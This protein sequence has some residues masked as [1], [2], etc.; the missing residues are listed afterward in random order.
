MTA[1]VPPPAI[2]RL[3]APFT[4]DY[5]SAPDVVFTAPDGYFDLP[6]PMF[7]EC[8]ELT[9]LTSPVFTTVWVH[10]AKPGETAY[11]SIDGDVVSEVTVANNR[12][13][14]TQVASGILTKGTHY[15][16]CT[17]DGV[18]V[19]RAMV[20]Q[21]APAPEFEPVAAD[22]PPEIVSEAAQ[23]NGNYRWVLQDLAQGGIG[24]WVMPINPSSMAPLPRQKEV[25]ASVTTSVGSSTTHLAESHP[26]PQ[27]WSFQGFCPDFEFYNRISQYKE[28]NR[29]F[30]LI[31][32]RNRAW[33]V[34]FNSLEM[35]PRKRLHG[36]DG[37]YND[38][39]H[40]Y[41]VKATV[42]E[43]QPKTPE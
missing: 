25:N 36:D 18:T 10:N 13:A 43:Q 30:Y 20:V 16:E 41:T 19:R 27:D 6:T 21:K 12:S 15:I 39:A 31:D 37:R 22:L 29:R 23:A 24:S 4:I 14:G 34:T 28:L 40:D 11:F 26:K 8:Y 9:F 5:R 7:L 1:Y 42:Y 32:H 17:V 38:W 3:T 2:L 33:V 35:K